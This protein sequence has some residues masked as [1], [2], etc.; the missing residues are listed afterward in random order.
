[1][2]CFYSFVRQTDSAY[3]GELTRGICREIR[4]VSMVLTLT[5]AGTTV[6]YCGSRSTSSKVMPSSVEGENLSILFKGVRE[7]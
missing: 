7:W 4:L 1:M 3:D 6:L 2:G 5:C